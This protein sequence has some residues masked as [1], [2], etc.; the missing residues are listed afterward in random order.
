MYSEALA[1]LV[2]TLHALFVVFVVC[3]GFLALRRPPLLGVH[4]PAMLWGAAVEFG[5]WICPLT[6]LENRLRAAAG[7]EV[8]AGDFIAHY[9]GLT[10]YPPALTRAVQVLLGAMVL[11]VNVIPYAILWQRWRHP[12]GQRSDAY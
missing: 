6:P 9:L 12:R 7:S 2:L 3:G 5:G 4:V 1:D 10:L 11:L 8:Y